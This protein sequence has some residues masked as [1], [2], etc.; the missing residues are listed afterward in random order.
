MPRRKSKYRS[1]LEDKL[2][3]ALLAVGGEYEPVS[4]TYPSAPR[5]YKPDVVLPNGV[6][7]EIKGWFVGSDRAKTLAVLKAYPGLDLRFILQTPSAPLDGRS[8]TTS[9]MWC[10]AHNIPWT[11]AGSGEELK[12]AR[13]PFN[14][15]SAAHLSNAPR[16]KKSRSD[17]KSAA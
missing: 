16:V 11:K 3:P 10:D 13:E 17:A 8:K 6:A 12:W 4:L 1:G 14:K 9:A 2:V 5:R 7:I 15:V